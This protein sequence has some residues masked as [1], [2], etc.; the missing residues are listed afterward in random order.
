M[1]SRYES[2][3]YLEQNTGWHVEDSAWKARHIGEMIDRLGVPHGRLCDI[4]CGAGEVVTQLST[5]YPEAE[6]TGFESSPQAYRLAASRSSE[7]RKFSM[8]NGLSESGFDIALAV[9]V[10]E[11]VDDYFG[12]L[13][14]MKQ[15]AALKIFHIP[16][17]MS[18]LGVALNNPMWSRR[19]VG[20]LHYFSRE[21]ALATLEDCG[22]EVLEWK[23][24]HS[25]LL[26]LKNPIA[27]GRTLRKL[28]KL[29]GL[30]LPRLLLGSIAPSFASRTLGG[31]SLLVAAR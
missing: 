11:H 10:F 2:G 18:A 28:S 20:H 30:G 29:V 12:F 25:Y 19:H 15:V 9:D 3:D 13:R 17:D 22:Y 1:T 4:G 14:A 23:F 26:E 5:R 8:A 6:F 31:L 24:T 21:T 27:G 16:L 7:K